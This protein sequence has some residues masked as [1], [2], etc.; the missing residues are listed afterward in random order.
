MSLIWM[1]LV[2]AFPSRVNTISMPRERK[3]VCARRRRLASARGF[4]GQLCLR[5]PFRQLL[6]FG[7]YINSYQPVTSRYKG[8]Q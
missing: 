7:A 6:E 3:A 2:P 5:K 8:N 1:I 4:F